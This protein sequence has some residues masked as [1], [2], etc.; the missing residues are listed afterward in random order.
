MICWHFCVFLTFSWYPYMKFSAS[1]F[2]CNC[3]LFMMYHSY[4]SVANTI[5]SLYYIYLSKVVSFM[6]LTEYKNTQLPH[7]I[8]IGYI[9]SYSFK[10]LIH[11]ALLKDFLFTSAHIPAK[12]ISFTPYIRYSCLFHFLF[13]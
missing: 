13:F 3:F 2:I 9:L 4:H 1:N 7:I 5:M 8:G 6:N 11:D 12:S 10:K